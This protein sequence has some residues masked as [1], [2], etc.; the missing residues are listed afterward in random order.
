M[1]QCQKEMLMNIVD[2]S[3]NIAGRVKQGATHHNKKR[4]IYGLRFTSPILLLSKKE[5]FEFPNAVGIESFVRL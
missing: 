2:I 1:T 4:S 3:K 5:I